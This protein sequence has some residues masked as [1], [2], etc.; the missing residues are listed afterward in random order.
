[1]KIVFLMLFAILTLTGCQTT[2]LSNLDN[3]N[4]C[5]VAVK[6]DISETITAKEAELIKE[7]FSNPTK[8][9]LKYPQIAKKVLGCLDGN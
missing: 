3:T 6:S 7:Y 4:T 5:Y 2:R 8:A 1:M 9:K